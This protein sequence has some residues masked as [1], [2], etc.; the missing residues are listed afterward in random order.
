[1][2][3]GL[4]SSWWEDES[5]NGDPRSLIMLQGILPDTPAVDP[6]VALRTA[7]KIWDVWGDEDIRGWGRPVLAINSAKI[8]NPERAIYHMTAYD[9]FKF[10]DAGKLLFFRLHLGQGPNGVSRLTLPLR[11]GFAIRGG[12]GK[13]QSQGF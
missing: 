4:N 3:E 2:Y 10:D 11:L 8:G 5:L 9:Y 6:K 13:S 7:D 12:S 1:M